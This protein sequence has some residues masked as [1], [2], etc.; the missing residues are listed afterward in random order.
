MLD[1]HDLGV[2]YGPIQAVRGVSL[3]VARGEVVALLGANGA[4]KSS[5]LKAVMGETADEGLKRGLGEVIRRLE[6]GGT[7][8]AAA[9]GLA[10]LFG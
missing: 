10:R 1:V 9:F 2:S 6:K 7:A 5:V 8:A 4:G 3:S